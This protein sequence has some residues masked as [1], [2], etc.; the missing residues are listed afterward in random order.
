M[1]RRAQ[2]GDRDRLSPEIANGANLLCP[3]Q[4]EA[5]NVQT[6]Q[7]DHWIARFHADDAWRRELAVDVDRAGGQVGRGGFTC[8][9]S[10]PDVLHVGKS[11]ALEKLFRHEL[12]SD[13][14]ASPVEQPDSRRLQR[15]L[16][17]K[18]FRSVNEPRCGS[19]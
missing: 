11:F 16:C 9:G 19:R 12:G 17:G 5:A 15:W 6:P 13:A 3:E 4:L 18:H 10:G 7:E 8:P 1:V 14:D 2:R